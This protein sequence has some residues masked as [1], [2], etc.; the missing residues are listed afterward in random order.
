MHMPRPTPNPLWPLRPGQGWRAFLAAGLLALT[1]SIG[2]PRHAQ[3]QAQAQDASAASTGWTSTAQDWINRQL[4]MGDS[5]EASATGLRPEVIVGALDTRLRLAPCAQV[6]PFVPQGT[7]LWGR[8]R[9]GLRCVEG[10]TRWTVFLPVTVKAWGPAW[11]IRQPVAPG[12]TLTLD[13]AELTEVDWAQSVSPVLPRAEDWVGTQAIRAMMPGQ[14]LR[15]A[16]V[17]PP[18]LF[19]AGT[20]VKV[21]V[22][23]GAV[24]L[25][26][27]GQALTHGYAGQTARVRMPNGRIV[28]GLVRDGQTVEI[29]L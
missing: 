22:E 14:V 3:A 13:D 16:M 20:Q 11:V 17:K 8:S 23:Q 28:T 6:E 24:R 21:L 18:Q 2:T 27:T 29:E 7:K 25:S 15:E 19:G 5:A 26:A 9:I 1:V 10:P 12:A 4:T